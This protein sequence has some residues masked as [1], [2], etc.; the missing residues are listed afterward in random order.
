MKIA[1][2]GAGFSG[3]AVAWHLSRELKAC[4]IEI[5]DPAGIGDNPSGISAG[6]LHPYPGKLCKLN[7]LAPEGIAA[8]MELLE[9]ASAALGHP[10]CLKS[11]LLRVALTAQQKNDFH[12]AAAQHPA[13]QWK[14][15]DACQALFPGLAPAPGVW[16][17]IA[18]TVATRDYLAGLWSACQKQGVTWNQSAVASLAELAAYDKIIVAAGAAVKNIREL[19]SLPITAIKGQIMEVA[20][21]EHLPPLQAPLSSQAYLVMRPSGKSCMVGA[22]FERYFSS[23]GPDQATALAWLKPRLLELFPAFGTPKVLAIKAGIRA[24][25]PAHLPLLKNYDA[26]TTVLT[27]MGS[28]GLLYHA[29]YAKKCTAAVISSLRPA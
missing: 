13:I 19:A 10:V 20:W 21:P 11:G 3:L 23:Q 5:F 27:G 28:K 24:S 18:W 17:E 14:E 22:T 16:I 29:F 7:N 4:A 8:T 1:V 12:L 15:P 25:A 6:L 2:I 26:K 9:E